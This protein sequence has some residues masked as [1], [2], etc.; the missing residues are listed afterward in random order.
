MFTN[1]FVCFLYVSSGL[2]NA[3]DFRKAQFIDDFLLID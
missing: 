1:E 3:A 2:K